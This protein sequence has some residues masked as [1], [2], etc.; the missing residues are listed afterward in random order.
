M[1]V[2]KQGKATLSGMFF[3]V[4]THLTAVCFRPGHSDSVLTQHVADMMDSCFFNSPHG[5]AEFLICHAA[6]ILLLAP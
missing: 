5:P 3:C 4:G 6:V 1:N 2:A